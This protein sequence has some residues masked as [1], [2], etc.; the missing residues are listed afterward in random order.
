MNRMLNKPYHDGVRAGKR[1]R[2]ATHRGDRFL[3]TSL[4]RE[5]RWFPWL[6]K[7][8]AIDGGACKALYW[9][10]PAICCLIASATEAFEP[11]S[12]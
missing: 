8:E 9:G 4:L 12:R 3:R 10:S 6:W 2:A 1:R 11:N 5:T 7:N